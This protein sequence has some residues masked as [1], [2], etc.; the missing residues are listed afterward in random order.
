MQNPTSRGGSGADRELELDPMRNWKLVI[1]RR[2]PEHRCA[3]G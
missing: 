2:L 3:A 1:S